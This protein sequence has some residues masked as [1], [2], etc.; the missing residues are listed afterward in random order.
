V[1]WWTDFRDGFEAIG[2]LVVNYF[3][4]GLGAAIAPF[5]SEGSRDM[6]F[7]NGYG[8]ALLALSG[9]IGGLQ[10]NMANYGSTLDWLS[11]NGGGA[12]SSSASTSENLFSNSGG[13][14][15]N[16]DNIE[17][18]KGLIQSGT[19][20]QLAMQYSG[21][22]PQQLQ[23]AGLDSGTMTFPYSSG[24]SI[25]GTPISPGTDLASYGPTNNLIG[26]P[27]GSPYGSPVSAM[28]KLSS[29]IGAIPWGSPGN[30]ANILQ[31]VTGVVQANR[32]KDWAKAA[33]PFA[34]YRQQYADKM[35]ALTADPSQIENQPGYAAGLQ[36]VKRG[37]AAQGLTG[38]GNLAVALQ[39][40]GGDFFN[41]TMDRYANWAGAG[42]NPGS[43]A[44]L[45]FN[46]DQFAME[47]ARRALG[48]F[49]S[50]GVLAG[51]QWPW[52]RG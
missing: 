14:V 44:Q 40:Y 2:S 7:G 43:A 42:V 25:A 12:G 9:G 31:G 45:G 36:A 38:S 4:P 23:T 52:M 26:G 6:L 48:N 28:S 1:S 51:N 41:Q 13:I 29:G 30:V 47:M 24:P 5:T 18:Y 20:P 8:Q 21:V 10:G 39:K 3:Y 11:G 22:T 32:M 49:G 27:S 33:D 50:A 19:D 35:A 16:P 46:Q 37:M 17:A 34:P 15:G